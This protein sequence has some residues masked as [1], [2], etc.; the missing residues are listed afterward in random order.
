MIAAASAS[1][2]S[3]SCLSVRVCAVLVFFERRQAGSFIF[4]K[5]NNQLELK[6][7]S[8]AGLLVRGV[9]ER[10]FRAFFKAQ[11]SFKKT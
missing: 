4:I 11:Y 10:G 5:H 6:A 9:A 8:K 3:M 1:V 7:C 2:A